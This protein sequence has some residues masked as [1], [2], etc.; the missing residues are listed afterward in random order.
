MRALLCQL[1]SSEQ[2]SV[3]LAL[4]M[5][6]TLMK[7]CRSIPALVTRGVMDEMINIANGK[8]GHRNQDESL[9]LIQS[10]GRTFEKRRELPIFYDVFMHLK[11]KGAQFPQLDP[12]DA[13][14]SPASISSPQPVRDEY[15]ELLSFLSHSHQK[16]GLPSRSRI[17]SDPTV[18]EAP[19]RFKSC[20]G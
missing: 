8:R 20:T 4:A 7:N 6:E 5:L 10:W 2:K 3:E 1:K 19:T 17:D 13:T 15:D 14:M 18:F 16:L 12:Q 9:R 11:S